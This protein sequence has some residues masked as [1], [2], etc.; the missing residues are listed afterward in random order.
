M[1]GNRMVPALLVGA[2]AVASLAGWAPLASAA[3]GAPAATGAPDGH[4]DAK[5]FCLFTQQDRGGLVWDRLSYDDD[6]HGTNV[7]Y[8]ARSWF[9]KSAYSWR[10]YSETHC[11]GAS[12]PL[13][14]GDWGNVNGQWYGHIKSMAREDPN[15]ASVRECRS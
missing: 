13:G 12:T 3:Q 5:E 4:C 10:V 7:G 2:V 8:Y 6:L 11:R 1:L 9:N 15:G 14:A